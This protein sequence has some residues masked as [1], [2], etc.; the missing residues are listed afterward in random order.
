MEPVVENATTVVERMA[1]FFAAE[2]PGA[3]ITDR[4]VFYQGKAE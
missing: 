1:S 3:D 4:P 2:I